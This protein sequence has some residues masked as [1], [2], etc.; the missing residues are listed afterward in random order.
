AAGTVTNVVPQAVSSSP[1]VGPQTPQPSY[2]PAPAPAPSQYESQR[3][4]PGSGTPNPVDAVHPH[5]NFD[6]GPA[7]DGDSNTYFNAPRLL[8]PRDH[9]ARSYQQRS[10]PTVDVW[11]AVYR[12]AANSPKASPTSQRPSTSRRSRT[13]AEIDADG[14]TAVQR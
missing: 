13:Q 1:S 9:T 14:W 4:A 6:P 7:K 8:D 3:P 12:S 11:T 10:K 2:T 5:D